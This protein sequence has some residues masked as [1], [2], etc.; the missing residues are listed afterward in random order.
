MSASAVD[1]VK[2]KINEFLAKVPVVD[3][4]VGKIAEKA[5]IDK[6]FIVIGA[7]V[8]CFLLVVLIGGG[9]FVL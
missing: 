1:S 8:L 2:A 5:K 6:A 3:E 9:N 4:Q 7:A